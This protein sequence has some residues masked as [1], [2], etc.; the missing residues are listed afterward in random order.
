[1]PSKTVQLELRLD[2]LYRLLQQ[3]SLSA[4]EFRCLDEASHQAGCWAVK[5]SCIQS[6]FSQHETTPPGKERIQV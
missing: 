3:R 6:I 5:A 1:M 2:V 4:C